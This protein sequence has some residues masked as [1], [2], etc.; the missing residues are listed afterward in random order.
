MVEDLHEVVRCAASREYDN[1]ASKCSGSWRCG[2]GPIHRRVYRRGQRQLKVAMPAIGE[3]VTVRSHCTRSEQESAIDPSLIYCL[4]VDTWNEMQSERLRR[5]VKF[6]KS[7]PTTNCIYICRHE[8]LLR[9]DLHYE[10][11]VLAGPNTPTPSKP[12][13]AG[14]MPKTHIPRYLGTASASRHTV[15]YA[16]RA[17]AAFIPSP[18]H[19]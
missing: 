9:R 8:I 16:S 12:P 6:Q 2:S 10:R 19:L 3:I 15:R 13:A 11:S 7:V 14:R 1:T 18:P 5:D 17:A 4:Q